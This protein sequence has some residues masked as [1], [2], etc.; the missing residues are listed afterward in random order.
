MLRDL[1]ALEVR[2]AQL[3]QLQRQEPDAA[4]REQMQGALAGI[5]EE[6]G[7][8]RLAGQ[9][10]ELRL[11]NLGLL[12]GQ[13]SLRNTV[14]VSAAA[15]AQAEESL[16]GTAAQAAAGPADSE[17]E[18]KGK[19]PAAGEQVQQPHAHAQQA[20]QQQQVEPAGP[21]ALV[22]RGIFSLGLE[23]F[24]A[25][26]VRRAGRRWAEFSLQQIGPSICSQC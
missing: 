13:Q 6:L 25:R 11:R 10:V 7:L 1:A 18:R 20:R 12:L 3:L 26:N 19:A 5:E 21:A 16:Q 14:A 24:Q 17:R 15:R 23:A 8:L 22:L 9:G 2:H 4:R